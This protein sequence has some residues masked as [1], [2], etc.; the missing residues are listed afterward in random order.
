MF[1]VGAPYGT[2]TFFLVSITLI[3]DL[4]LNRW[5]IFAECKYLLHRHNN[6][7]DGTLKV[8]RVGLPYGIPTVVLVSNSSDLLGF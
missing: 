8:F 5:L 6:W 4:L 3:L 2:P 7:T 1:L